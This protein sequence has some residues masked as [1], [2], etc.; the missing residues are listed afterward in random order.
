MIRVLIVD[1]DIH[2]GNGTQHLF[3]SDPRYGLA[4]TLA[5]CH[6][7]CCFNFLLDAFSAPFF[8][9]VRKPMRVLTWTCRNGISLQCSCLAKFQLY[10]WPPFTSADW[11][12]NQSTVRLNKKVCCDLFFASHCVMFGLFLVFCTSPYIDMT[13]LSFFHFPRVLIMM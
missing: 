5:K 7:S 8:F 2:H 9:F 1:W 10:H 6:G 13:M 4:K 3:E 12:F 11:P